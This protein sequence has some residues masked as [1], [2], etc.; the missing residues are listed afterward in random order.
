ME[1]IEIALDPTTATKLANII[2]ETVSKS[3]PRQTVQATIDKVSACVTNE[4]QKLILQMQRE[5]QILKNQIDQLKAKETPTVIKQ[6]P[7]T[8]PKTTTAK[9][10]THQ[11]K[12]KTY[13]EALYGKNDEISLNIS[14]IQQQCTQIRA[15]PQTTT[16]NFIKER[17]QPP[18]PQKVEISA[19]WIIDTPD[20]KE[21]SY[22]TWREQLK[23]KGAPDKSIIELRHPLKNVVEVITTT[24]HL[25]KVMQAAA[26]LNNRITIP[27]PYQRVWEA[28]E[29]LTATQILRMAKSYATA[30]KRTPIKAVRIYLNLVAMEGITILQRSNSQPQI[31]QLQEL[32]QGK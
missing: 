20:P 1:G 28:P 25:D 2:K 27:S 12:Q 23:A 4:M 10:Q 18:P 22:K 7:N 29:E 6:E 26:Q 15:K 8:D 21:V 11:R 14:N 5:I 3:V 31:E 19:F 13:K 30:I 17:K 16:M 9:N 24:Q 32:M